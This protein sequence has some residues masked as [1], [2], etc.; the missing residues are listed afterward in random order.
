MSSALRSVWASTLL[1]RVSFSPSL[2]QPMGEALVLSA[3]KVTSDR[4]TAAAGSNPAQASRER[5]ASDYRW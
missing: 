4:A 1:P 3:L 5:T 2:I